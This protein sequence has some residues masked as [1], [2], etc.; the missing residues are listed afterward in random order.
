VL[1]A[2][3]QRARV[4]PHWLPPL[5]PFSATAETRFC[6]ATTI[7]ASRSA[8]DLVCNQPERAYRIARAGF[9][10][11]DDPRLGFGRFHNI[12]ELARRPL[13]TKAPI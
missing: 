8:L 2:D 11:R 1:T 4:P 5:G 9:N 13:P 12:L 7:I 10:L 6:F 3:G